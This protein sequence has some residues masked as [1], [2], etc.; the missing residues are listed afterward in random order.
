MSLEKTDTAKG[1]AETPLRT[2][3]PPGRQLHGLIAL[4]GDKKE[5]H[6]ERS[7]HS[8]LIGGVG[9]LSKLRLMNKLT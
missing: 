7:W 6:R 9:P 4:R 2:G 8:M 3:A 1:V 5:K